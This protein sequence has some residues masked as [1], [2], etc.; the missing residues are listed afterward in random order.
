M[1]STYTETQRFS[2]RWLWTLII[3]LMLVV[4]AVFGYG[5]LKQLVFGQTWGGR[6]LTNH[7]LLVIGTL[8]IGFSF[9][10]IYLFY[11]LKLITEVRD[12]GVH[13]RF[14]PLRTKIIS[15]ESIRSCEARDYK[16]LAEYGGW[17][18]KY[19]RSGWAYNISG[20]RGV[21]LVLKDNK[22][23]L[24]GSQRADEL[25]Q[26]RGPLHDAGIVLHVNGG[27]HRVDQVQDIGRTAHFLQLPPPL[28]FIGATGI[29]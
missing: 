1:A 15:Y 5:I 8:V 23:I 10:M 17:G 27:G 2:Q 3:T 6:P 9:A 13:I 24:I 16:P 4:A 21:Q 25:A 22:R 29:V 28:Q 18:I 19:G 11:N 12:T 7:I 26:Y 20:H 14:Y